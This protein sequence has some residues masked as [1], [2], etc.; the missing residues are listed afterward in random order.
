MQ[1]KITKETDKDG[2]WFVARKEDNEPLVVGRKV[3]ELEEYLRLNK[4]LIKNGKIVEEI[5][6]IEL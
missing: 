4:E 5:K 2:T 1:I 3:E 6:T